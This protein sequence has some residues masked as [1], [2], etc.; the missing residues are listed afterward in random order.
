M[1]KE[2]ICKGLGK[3]KGNGCGN[4]IEKHKF[5]LGISCCYNE[6]LASTE[7]GEIELAKIIASAKKRVAIENRKKT[8]EEKK[9][10][11]IDILSK[12]EYRKKILQPNINLI[13]R[14]IDYGQPCISTG[15][16]NGKMSGGH[17]VDTKSNSAICLN[18]HNIFIQSFASN[19]HKSGDI[20]KY[21][22]GIIKTFGNEYFNFIQ[23][24]RR[25]EQIEFT[26][27]DFINANDKAKTIIKD[28]KKDLT[29]KTPEQR[30]NLR[31]K[32]NFQL[33]IYKGNY[34]FF[35]INQNKL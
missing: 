6:W 32:V 5:G 23:L 15:N 7:E 11:K 4:V 12:N 29:I 18:L 9:K 26:K 8:I 27:Q 31:N 28:L 34:C 33:N 16:I 14:L 24:L 2:R 25:H 3:A 22:D 1:K 35:K 13:A 20:L 10:M 21:Q 30:I 19:H 17:Y